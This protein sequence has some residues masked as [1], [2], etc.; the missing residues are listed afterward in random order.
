[1]TSI[2]HNAVNL[3]LYLLQY[4]R[5]EGVGIRR[6][7]FQRASSCTATILAIPLFNFCISASQKF[8][9]FLAPAER[10]ASAILYSLISLLPVAV[11]QCQEEINSEVCLL[12]T[13]ERSSCGMTN[14]EIK[15]KISSSS[16][17]LRSL[18]PGN[19]GGLGYSW[20]VAAKWM[21]K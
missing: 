10:I 15:F 9:G 21:V 2:C 19:C 7:P 1:M 11:L 16:S 12:G 6:Q 13:N 3:V 14:V 4:I 17:L 20:S 5:A 8:D 18:Q